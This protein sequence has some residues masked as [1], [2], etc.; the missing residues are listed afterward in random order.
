[1]LSV[2]W[3]M[4][5]GK[6]ILMG[7]TVSMVINSIANGIR[8]QVAKFTPWI[9]CTDTVLVTRGGNKNVE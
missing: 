7:K 8:C 2:N 4:A 9:Q 1:M 3:D 5:T 6:L